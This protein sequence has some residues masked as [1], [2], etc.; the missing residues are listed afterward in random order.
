MK[1]MAERKTNVNPS[2]I[3]MVPYDMDTNEYN[4]IVFEL[5]DFFKRKELTVKQAQS[6]LHCCEEML[7]Y[8]VVNI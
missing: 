1:I 7:L 8:S 3:T 4:A 2:V 6:V 5:C